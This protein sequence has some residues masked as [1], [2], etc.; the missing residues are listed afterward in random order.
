MVE[1]WLAAVNRADAEQVEALTAERVE[2]VGPR[3]S[4]LMDRAVLSEWMI[5]AGFSSQARRWFCGADG[6][7]VVEQAARW[8]DPYSGQE[9]GQAIVASDFVVADGHVVRY[10]RHDAALDPALRSAGLTDRDEVVER[11]AYRTGRDK[12]G[13]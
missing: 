4:G 5:R 1:E 11:G 9:G 13:L 2:I 12:P 10:A 7:V 3:G 8:A 6:R